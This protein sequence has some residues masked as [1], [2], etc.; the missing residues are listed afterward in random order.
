MFRHRGTEKIV[1]ADEIQDKVAAME[2]THGTVPGTG[3]DCKDTESGNQMDMGHFPEVFLVNEEEEAS[4][5]GQENTDRPLGQGGESCKDVAEEIVFPVIRVSQIEESHGAAHEKEEGG[6]GDN[7]LGKDPAFH[8]GTKDKG[9]KPAYLFSVG[10]AAEPVGK[11]YGCR[12][13]NGCGQAG[14]HFIEP[15]KGKGQGQLPIVEYGLVIPVAAVNLRGNPVS[16]KDHFLCGEGI[17]RFCRVRDC[18]KLV[19]H[20]VDN[21]G[22]NK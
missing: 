14:S 3:D 9:R 5:P 8:R 4:Q 22:E 18:Q 15:E 13:Q 20:E 10:S 16:R 1:D 7:S 21:K 6:V 2:V 19:A 17:V 11:E 12:P